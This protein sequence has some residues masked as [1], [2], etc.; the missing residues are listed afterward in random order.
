MNR[1]AILRGGVHIDA[2]GEVRHVNSFDLGTADRFY[3]IAP[4]HVGEWRGWTGHRRDRKWFFAVTGELVICIAAVTELERGNSPEVFRVRLSAREAQ[5]LE[6]PPGFATA[7]Q[8]CEI[9][10]SLLVMSTGRIDSAAEDM[11]RYPIS[12][13]SLWQDKPLDQP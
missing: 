8:A 7:I 4:A 9:P 1:P 10:A 3:V 5:L 2:R 11:L 6:V 12:D 13:P